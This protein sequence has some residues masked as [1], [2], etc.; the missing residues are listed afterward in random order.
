MMRQLFIVVLLGALCASSAAQPADSPALRITHS[1]LRLNPELLRAFEAFE[2]GDIATAQAKYAQVLQA[3]PNN[4]DAL[5]GAAAVALRRNDRS[6]A[7]DLYR[8]AVSADPRDAVAHAGLAGLFAES[9]PLEAENRLKTL[10][11][12]QPDEPSLHFALGNV[13]ATAGRWH[14][15]Q[16]AF[17]SAHSA[18]PEQ[19]DYLFNLAVSLDQLRQGKLARQYYEKAL[20]LAARRPAGFDPAEA[21]TRLKSLPP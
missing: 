1:R 20:A 15:A 19:S 14:D 11:A 4:A 10:I 13:Y 8:R 18:D 12:A 17:F 21:T 3:E 9:D 16:R 6:R 7:A 2:A 5:H